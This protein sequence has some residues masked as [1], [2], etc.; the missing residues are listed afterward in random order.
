MGRRHTRAAPHGGVRRRRSAR[1]ERADVRGLR[2]LLSLGH[3]ELDP[4]V[5]VQAAVARGLD[6][7][8]VGEDVGAAVVRGDEPEALVRVEPLHYARNHARLLDGRSLPASM[9]GN[10]VV[11]PA[12]RESRAAVL[13]ARTGETR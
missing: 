5:L 12:L 10:E 11:R 4:L 1:S 2:A 13:I 3:L 8:E 9:D 7:G 6:R